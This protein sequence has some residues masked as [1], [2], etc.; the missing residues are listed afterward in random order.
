MSGLRLP[1]KLNGVAILWSLSVLCRLAIASPNDAGCVCTYGEPCWPSADKFAQLQSE[2]SQ[3]LIYPSPTASACYP[4]AN[5][6]GNCSEVVQHWTDGNWRSNLPG[7]MDAPN[8]ESFIFKNDTISACYLNTSLG[9][10]C[11]QGNLPV[12]G[13]DARTPQDIQTAVKFAIQ[14]NLKLVIKNTG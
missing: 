8:F 1:Q 2:V 13:V 9:I 11:E 5:P 12:I 3:P 4:V 14:Y 6:S 7:S 10:P